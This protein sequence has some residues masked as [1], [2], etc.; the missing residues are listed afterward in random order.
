MVRSLEE[1][2]L[3]L[4]LAGGEGVPPPDKLPPPGAFLDR[5][6]RNI[7]EAFLAV[8][9]SGEGGSP[10]PRE[11]LERLPN[12]G[13]SVDRMARLLLEESV[14]SDPRELE[15]SVFRLLRR[16]QQQRARELA[17]RIA[18]AQRAGDQ[19]TLKRLLDEKAALSRQLHSQPSAQ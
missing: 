16:W 17:A 11:V 10:K 9:E 3:Q 13:E 4:L 5:S 12:E 6:C 14:D 7:Y 18:D 2:T 8:Y 15:G 19:E 1:K